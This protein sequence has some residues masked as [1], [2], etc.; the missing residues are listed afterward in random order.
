MLGLTG[1]CNSRFAGV[2]VGSRSPRD[3]SLSV[4]ISLAPLSRDSTRFGT[5]NE[6]VE[7]SIVQLEHLGESAYNGYSCL[8][9]CLKLNRTDT[10]E[11]GRVL[12]SIKAGKRLP[13]AQ[14]SNISIAPKNQKSVY[15]MFKKGDSGSDSEA[16][17]KGLS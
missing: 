6:A 3:L 10:D 16:S 14:F 5:P 2:P 11:H 4:G 13:E 1:E 12:E 7:A 8:T 17:S 9:R 15:G